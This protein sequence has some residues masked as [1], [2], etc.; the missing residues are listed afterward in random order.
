[1][2]LLQRIALNVNAFRL[3]W[4]SRFSIFF[5]A[6]VDVVLAIFAT[7]TSQVSSMRKRVDKGLSNWF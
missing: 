6:G 2:L 3:L 1:M 4:A 5:F 7:I